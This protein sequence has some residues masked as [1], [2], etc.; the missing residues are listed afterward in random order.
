MNKT[1]EDK[2]DRQLYWQLSCQL[3]D[4]DGK[5]GLF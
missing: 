4:K 2:L 1:F 3:W 5:Q